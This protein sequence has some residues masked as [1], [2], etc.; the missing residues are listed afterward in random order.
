MTLVGKIFTMLIFVMSIVFMAFAIMVF[1]THTNWRTES[2]ALKTQLVQKEQLLKQAT[3]EHDKTK[4]DLAQEQASRRQ[5]LAALQTKLQA[6]QEQL[7]AKTQ[8]LTDKESQ[9]NEAA[10]ALKSSE[11]RLTALTDELTK[12][13]QLLKIA[14]QER[15]DIF[16]QVVAL[17][18]KFNQSETARQDLDRRNSQL[19][20]QSA[21]ME[22][23]RKANGLTVDSL[24]AHIPPPVEGIVMDVGSSDL[25]EISIG[26][27]DGLKIGHTLDV[28][29][30]NNYLGRIVV[31]KTAPDRA[32]GQV[33]KEL[34]RGQIKKGDHVTTKLS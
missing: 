34:K 14:Q 17:T 33:V 2:G 20:A 5:A 27:D 6:S 21:D 4:R 3:E 16:L 8:Q 24:V 9:L 29:R 10:A 18:D 7:V 23:V 30:G 31:R 25:I 19:V 15:D 13:R 28:Y 12:N 1:A 26:H 32:V 22:R 11:D